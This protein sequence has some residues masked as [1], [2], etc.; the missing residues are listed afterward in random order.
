MSYLY[1]ALN[2]KSFNALST[3]VFREERSFKTTPKT[4]N[5]SVDLG[6]RSLGWP[7]AN[8]E[9]NAKNLSRPGYILPNPVGEL[10]ALPHP[11]PSWWKGLDAPS[12]ESQSP[13]L[14][15]ALQYTDHLILD[16]RV[17]RLNA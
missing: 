11:D 7:L 1:I 5:S 2:I 10:I 12:K 6:G 13:L 8:A 14:G 16:P 17:A 3:L 4:L 9:I 15:F